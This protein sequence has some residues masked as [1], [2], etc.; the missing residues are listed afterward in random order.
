MQKKS[1]ITINWGSISDAAVK[2]QADAKGQSNVVKSNH[3][4]LLI[5]AIGLIAG[6]FIILIVLG[7][8]YYFRGAHIGYKKILIENL[9]V[10][11]FVGIIEFLFFTKVAAK[12][13]PV[14]PDILAETVLDRVKYRLGQY[15]L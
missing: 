6:L 15:F 9:I 8:Y 4:K 1:G 14:T 10:F 3:R 12:Y 13:I 5:T 2:M 11:S 7:I